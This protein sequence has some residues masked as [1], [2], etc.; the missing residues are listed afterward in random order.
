MQ[1]LL[2]TNILIHR[3]AAV[4]VRDDI[5][6]VFRWLDRLKH[7]KLVHP[8]SLDEVRK[9]NDPRVVRT[10]ERKLSSYTILQQLSPDTPEIASIR[11]TDRTENDRND[12]SLLAE[13]AAERVDILITEDRGIHE[14]AEK[15]GLGP[16]VFTIDGFLEKITAENPNLATYSVLAVQ[17]Q[18]FGQVQLDQPFFDSFKADYPGFERWFR[19][20]A[21]ETAYTCIGPNGEL[22]AFL[23]VK[24]EGPDEYYGDISPAL[25]PGRRLKVGTF[26]VI[27]NGYKLGERFLKIIFDN[28][29]RFRVEEIY[30]TIFRHRDELDR[31]VALLMDWG[32]IYH[33]VKQ[34]DGGTEEVYRRSFRPEADRSRP[35]RTYPYCAGSARKFIVA[36]YPKYHTELLPDSILRTES[37]LQFTENR[38]N[39]N[40]IQKVFVSRSIERSMQSG[41]LIVFYRT[42]DAGAGYYTSVATTLGIVHS[43]ITNIRDKEE[44]FA[45]CRKRS[46]FSDA[47]LEEHWDYNPRSRPFIVNFL[48]VESFPRRPNNKKLRELG[49]IAEAPRGFHELSDLAFRT[50]LRAATANES[51]VVD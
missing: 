1:V 14:K 44:F 5:G 35:Q 32:F 20:K 6:A 30:V 19:R 4:I 12:T 25:H 45:L 36:I 26:K 13:V 11:L 51:L 49:I 16:R 40:A 10:M 3:E 47:E 15:L 24:L 17:K 8:A 23:Y 9:H 42:K 38:P 22:L 31:L 37:P 34:S 33:G 7:E 21:D 43:V 46:V 41:D 39:R 2:D 48:Y 50:L 27:S 18:Q 28:A 29:L